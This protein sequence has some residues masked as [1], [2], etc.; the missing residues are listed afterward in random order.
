MAR[1]LGTTNTRLGLDPNSPFKVAK[2]YSTPGSYTLELPQSATSAKVYVVG[3]GSSYCA[4]KYCA[5]SSNCW[6]GVEYP[7]C[8]YSFEFCGHLTGA[9][10][11]YAEKTYMNN[12]AGASLNISVASPAFSSNA[13]FTSSS[14]TA[15]VPGAV[16]NAIGTG[17]TYT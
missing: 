6:L 15:Y 2:V 13:A 3:A 16:A 1:F 10:G 12:V 14:N 8:D 11:G 9:G 17:S 5:T 4:G 7:I